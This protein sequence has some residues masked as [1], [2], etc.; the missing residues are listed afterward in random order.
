MNCSNPKDAPVTIPYLAPNQYPMRDMNNMDNKVTDPPIGIFHNFRYE[1]MSANVI[2]I[3][4]KTSFLV[5]A[6]EEV[7]AT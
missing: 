5:V 4:E 7:S 3:A 6:N 2:P 1:V